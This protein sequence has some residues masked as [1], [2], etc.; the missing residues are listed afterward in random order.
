MATEIKKSVCMWCHCHCKVDVHVTGG[1]LDKIEGVTNDPRSEG[2]R[3]TV[4]ACARPR[5]AA[6]YLYHPDRLRYPLKRKGERCRTDPI[7]QRPRTDCR[8]VLAVRKQ[9]LQRLPDGRDGSSLAAPLN[10]NAHEVRRTQRN[11]LQGCQPG[12]VP[13]APVAVEIE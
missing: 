2:I 1:R 8:S 4:A 7:G 11:K 12:A 10:N 6:E 9:N 13:R 5:A 3:R